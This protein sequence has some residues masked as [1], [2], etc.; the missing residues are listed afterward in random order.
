[1]QY[2]T[3][4]AVSN[5]NQKKYGSP[6]EYE[7]ISW[8]ILWEFSHNYWT[9]YYCY[10]KSF[11]SHSDDGENAPWRP[12]TYLICL[13]ETWEAGIFVMALWLRTTDFSQIFAEIWGNLLSLLW[14]KDRRSSSGSPD[15]S[16]SSILF[17][18]RTVR[19][20]ERTTHCREQA[21]HKSCA[22][23]GRKFG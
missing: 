18:A 9:L 19:S 2:K 11:Y 16:I 20:Q 13:A 22:F 4:W 17:S 14:D 5:S 12:N 15:T 10:S 7:S 23:I 1:M 21:H 3:L 8:G 6:Q